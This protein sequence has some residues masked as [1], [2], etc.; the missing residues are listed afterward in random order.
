MRRN[1]K[2]RGEE[3]GEGGEDLTK[4]FAHGFTTKAEGH[5]FGLHHS[6]NSAT[7]MGGSLAAMSEGPG[8]GATFTLRLP[9]DTW[10]GEATDTT[11]GTGASPTALE[12]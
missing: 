8:H 3:R 2:K 7:E 6:A 12:S 1:R 10:R 9:L 5:G 11:Q 4:I